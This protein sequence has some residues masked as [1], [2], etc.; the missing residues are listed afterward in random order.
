MAKIIYIVPDLKKFVPFDPKETEHARVDLSKFNADIFNISSDEKDRLDNEYLDFLAGLAQ[1]DR[2]V[3]W[4]ANAVSERNELLSRFYTRLLTLHCL[5]RYITDNRLTNVVIVCPD[6]L[7]V[8]PLIDQFR[9]EF[10]VVWEAARWTVYR[11]RVYNGLRFFVKLGFLLIDKISRMLISRIYLKRKF[12]NRRITAAHAIKVWVDH[13]SYAKGEY[14]DAYF[15]RLIDYLKESQAEHILLAD[16]IQ[17]YHQNIRRIAQDGHNTILP[18]EYFFSL[19]DLFQAVISSFKHRPH[20]RE[21]LTFGHVDAS[22]LVRNELEESFS[23][24]RFLQNIFYYYQ[25]KSLAKNVPLKS[26]TYTFEN[27]AWEKMCLLALKESDR[28]IKCIGFQHAFIAKN[29]F[30]YFLG[31]EEAAIVPKPDRIVTMGKVTERILRQYG[32]WPQEILK[33]GCALRQIQ[34]AQPV[35]VKYGECRDLL[36]P[37]TMTADESVRILNFLYEAGLGEYPGKV[38]LRFHPQTPVKKVFKQL[39]F[40]LPENFIISEGQ[41]LKEDLARAGLVLCT[42]TTVGLEALMAGLPVIYLDVNRPLD[43]DPL[44]EW[45]HL[46]ERAGLPEELKGK[47]ERLLNLDQEDY[48]SSLEK[49]RQ[50]LK[51]YFYPITEQSLKQFVH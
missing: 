41:P 20:V 44:F 47:I 51:E 39:P 9:P 30:K 49:S 40:T 36:V 15:T 37:F 27:Y 50:Y 24:T 21:A 34:T 26:F 11:W 46:K 43:L 48:R 16:V 19:G 3:F 5:K 4:W 12:L 45:T 13:R 10:K 17:D 31:K 42:W 29:S 23:G 38:I 28:G 25:I 18:L 14:N 2:S 22:S 8:G 1:R 35:T 32:H 6:A 7:L 33:T